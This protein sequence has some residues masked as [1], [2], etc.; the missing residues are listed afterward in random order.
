MSRFTGKPEEPI[1]ARISRLRVCHAGNNRGNPSPSWPG[2]GQVARPSIKVVCRSLRAVDRGT[3]AHQQ[4]WKPPG[5]SCLS[6]ADSQV[7]VLAGNTFWHARWD[8]LR[9]HHQL[10]ACRRDAQSHTRSFLRIISRS[11]MRSRLS[12]KPSSSALSR[13]RA[14]EVSSGKGSHLK[15]LSMK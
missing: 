1:E 7:T 3:K 6:V 13:E 4:S 10:P 14:R 15:A 9:K 12:S 11:T 8:P 5:S 2:I